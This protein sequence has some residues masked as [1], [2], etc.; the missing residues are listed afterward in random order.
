M[1][2]AAAIRGQAEPTI[3]PSSLQAWKSVH[4][5]GNKYASSIRYL[6]LESIPQL[7]HTY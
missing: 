6:R 2:S 1:Q 4:G 7:T 5:F 3:G